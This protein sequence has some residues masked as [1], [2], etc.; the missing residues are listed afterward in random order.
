MRDKIFTAKLR[1]SLTLF[2]SENKYNFISDYTLKFYSKK[3]YLLDTTVIHA[4][5]RKKHDSKKMHSVFIGSS[6]RFLLIDDIWLRYYDNSWD[7]STIG[8]SSRNKKHLAMPGIFLIDP[9]DP[10]IIAKS[11]NHVIESYFTLQNQLY[12][13]SNIKKLNEIFN[14]NPEESYLKIY[15]TQKRSFI[16]TFQRLIIAHYANN[17]RFEEIYI[18]NKEDI[19]TLIDRHPDSESYGKALS[20]Y[21]DI[22]KR[23]KNREIKRPD[24]LIEKDNPSL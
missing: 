16:M 4:G 7:S 21:E 5:S 1:E 3:K 23:I 9:K 8:F 22:Y 6:R 18:E 15:S 14:G 10:D 19:L 17:S 24:F 13:F 11:K 20:S 2:M 12:Y